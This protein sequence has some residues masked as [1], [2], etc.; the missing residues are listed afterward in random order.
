MGDTAA[1]HGR[2]RLEGEGVLR[3]RDEDGQRRLRQVAAAA[4]SV[5][6]RGRSEVLGDEV[7]GVPPLGGLLALRGG[8]RH[9]CNGESVRPLNNWVGSAVLWCYVMSMTLCN[10]VTIL[11]FPATRGSEDLD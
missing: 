1:E 4:E 7:E 6:R 11:L 2:R 9:T 5:A 3:L 8:R 10:E